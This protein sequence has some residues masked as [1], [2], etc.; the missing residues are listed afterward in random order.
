MTKQDRLFIA[1]VQLGLRS[2]YSEMIELL[3]HVN[4]KHGLKLGSWQKMTGRDGAKIM[5]DPGK[6]IDDEPVGIRH[7]IKGFA[8]TILEMSKQE[9][10]KLTT[11]VAK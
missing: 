9:R 10:A 8:H 2:A 7:A 5:L 4:T 6:I 11:K 3:D 1:G